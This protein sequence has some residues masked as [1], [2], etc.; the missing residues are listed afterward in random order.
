MLTGTAIIFETNITRG[1]DSF[2]SDEIKAA[3][4]TAICDPLESVLLEGNF[5]RCVMRSSAES[6]FGHAQEHHL[7]VKVPGQSIITGFAY[8]TPTQATDLYL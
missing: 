4:V 6:C 5:I 7:A 1:E 2:E 8:V 3:F